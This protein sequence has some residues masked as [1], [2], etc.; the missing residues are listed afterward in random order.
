[1]KRSALL[2]YKS[3]ELHPNYGR[4][5]SEESRKKMS[6]AQKGKKHSEETKLKMSKSHKGVGHSEESKKKICKAWILRKQK[7]ER[8]ELIFKLNSPEVRKK[9]AETMKRNR[10]AKLNELNNK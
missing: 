9:A 10:L 2:R 1:M 5:A 6:E 3:K 7:I 8:G 4:K